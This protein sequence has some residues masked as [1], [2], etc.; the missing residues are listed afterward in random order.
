M[1]LVPITIFVLNFHFFSVYFFCQQKGTLLYH[2]QAQNESREQRKE[3]QR[4]SFLPRYFLS[5]FFT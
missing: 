1:H 5:L 3:N 2:N 4:A